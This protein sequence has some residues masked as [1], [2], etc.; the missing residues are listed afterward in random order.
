MIEDGLLPTINAQKG[1]INEALGKLS[2]DARRAST[3][4]FRKAWRLARK[5]DAESSESPVEPSGQE[6]RALVQDWYFAQ[7]RQK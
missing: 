5:K 6:K 2:P 3:R 4:R 1:Q 7:A